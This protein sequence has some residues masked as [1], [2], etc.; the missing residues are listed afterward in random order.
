MEAF[1]CVAAPL[2]LK[3]VTSHRTP[4]SSPFWSRPLFTVRQPGNREDYGVRRDVAALAFPRSGETGPPPRSARRPLRMWAKVSRMR[5][6]GARVRTPS[7]RC[8]YLNGYLQLRRKKEAPP[9]FLWVPL[10][11]SAVKNPLLPPLA[12]VLPRTYTIPA[13]GYRSVLDG[14]SVHKG[15]W[16]PQESLKRQKI[17]E[18]GYARMA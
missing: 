14:Y 15:L 9:G 18:V 10:G 3:A 6:G 4:Q 16:H 12:S 5:R 11:M 13:Q 17:E 7:P 1:A 8:P 2:A